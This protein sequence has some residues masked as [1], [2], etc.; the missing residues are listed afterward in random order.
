VLTGTP[1]AFAA[2]FSFAGLNV[3]AGELYAIT[4]GPLSSGG[5]TWNGDLPGSYE[6][7]YAVSSYDFGMTWGVV[8]FD[9]GDECDLGFTVT[10]RTVPEPNTLFL[11]LAA[12][13]M[14]FR[15]RSKLPIVS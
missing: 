13:A 15:R 6:G 10:A 14:F 12:L 4:I 11:A 8:H 7:G 2:D 9:P 5:Y 1:T 3:T